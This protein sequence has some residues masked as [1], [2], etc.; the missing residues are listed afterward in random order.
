MSDDKTLDQLRAE[1]E[2]RAAEAEQLAEQQQSMELAVTGDTLQ[3]PEVMRGRMEELRSMVKAKQEEVRE[4]HK[5]VKD[6]LERQMYAQRKELERISDAASA[7]LEPLEKIVEVMKEGIWTLSLYMGLREQIVQVRDG[8]PA[9]AT[10]PIT[11]RQMVLAMDEETGLLADEGGLTVE[12]VGQFD[13]WLREDFS[14][15]EQIVPEPKG[16]VAMVARWTSRDEGD[17]WSHDPKDKVTQFIVRNGEQVFRVSADF[18]AGDV[19][20]PRADEFVKYFFRTRY[21]HKIHQDVRVPLKPGTKDYDLAMEESDKRGRHYLRIGLILQGLVD[22]TEVFAPLHPAGINM[23]VDPGERGEK[24]RIITDAEGALESGA[25]SFVDWHEEA[26]QQFRVGLRVVGSFGKTYE[27]QAYGWDDSTESL[28]DERIHPRGAERPKDGVPYVLEDRREDGGFVIRYARTQKTYTSEWIEDPETPGYG[29]RGGYRL[30]KTRASCVVYSSDSFVLPYDLVDSATMERFLRNRRDRREYK[31]LWP[32]MRAV[33]RAKRAE[34]MAEAPFLEMMRGVCARENGVMPS[35]QEVADL[36]RWFKLKNRWHRPLLFAQLLEVEEHERTR[37]GRVKR[38]GK[39]TVREE[40]EVTDDAEAQALAVRMITAEHKRRVKDRQRPINEHVVAGLRAAHPECLLIARPRSGGYLVLEAAESAT[41][42]FVHEH[43]YNASG[44]HKATAEWQLVDTDRPTRWTVAYEHPRWAQWDR[45][46]TLRD[47]ITGPERDELAAKLEEEYGDDLM[48]LD[49][50]PRDKAFTAWVYDQVGDWDEDHLLTV[51]PSEP[52]Y[53]AYTRRWRRKGREAPRLDRGSTYKSSAWSWNPAKDNA[54]WEGSY[55]RRGGTGIRVMENP[56]PL[57][58]YKARHAEYRVIDKRRRAL[59]QR[60]LD[61]LKSLELQAYERK[62]AV[63]RERWLGRGGSLEEWQEERANHRDLRVEL[64]SSFSRGANALER[65]IDVLVEDGAD[66]DGMAV[67]ELAAAARERGFDD[68]EFAQ[69]IF[70]DKIPRAARGL[71]VDLSL[72]EEPD[73]PDEE[74]DWDDD[75]E[76]LD[77]DE[78][79]D[80]DVVADLG[81]DVHVVGPEEAKPEGDVFDALRD[82]VKGKR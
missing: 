72:L 64:R 24:V 22:R 79:D 47:W 38:G 3:D 78:L 80:D 50:R 27:R 30:P 43:T 12:T 28:Q 9:P 25:Q 37:S 14:R 81:D 16:V 15:V 7:A 61:V 51:R 42:V 19:L 20:V 69:D 34:E 8:A 6:E 54:P 41:D 29:W 40:L 60:A 49:Y 76:E 52:D 2:E 36:A 39:V 59:V 58:A 71:R 13:A 48:R 53:R 5:A 68:E 57:D 44:E 56:A 46:A 67:E 23:L 63:D 11:I 75:D 33:W 73:E 21:D 55:A 26:N 65:I 1:L 35:E 10:T 4:S 82:A 45:A 31:T 17:P 32:L 62:A 70:N 74:E 66:L 18:H 77:E